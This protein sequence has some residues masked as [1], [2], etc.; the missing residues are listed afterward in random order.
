M[1]FK[2]LFAYS[3]ARIYSSSDVTTANFSCLPVSS[4]LLTAKTGIGNTPFCI[5]FI[6]YQTK[7]K[8]VMKTV[9]DTSCLRTR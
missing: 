7:K 3:I 4:T 8:H 6:F 9:Y 5:F 1:K 2:I